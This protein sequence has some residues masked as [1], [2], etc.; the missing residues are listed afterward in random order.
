MNK[1][2]RSQLV[3]NHLS[4]KVVQLFDE[5]LNKVFPNIRK[6]Y[7]YRLPPVFNFQAGL[8]W[9]MKDEVSMIEKS[10]NFAVKNNQNDK[11]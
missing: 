4:I 5:V 9:V 11:Y 3:V 6:K 10:C 7:A 1:V 8:Y 2:I